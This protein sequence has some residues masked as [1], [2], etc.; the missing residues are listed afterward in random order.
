MSVSSCS[1]CASVIGEK[2]IDKQ[3]RKLIPAPVGELFAQGGFL[4]FADAGAGNFG[5]EDEGVGE[6]PLRE[7]FCEVRA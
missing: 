2:S 5:H 4:E 7:R 3:G 6:L 1:Y